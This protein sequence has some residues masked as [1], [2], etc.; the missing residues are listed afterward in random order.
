MARAEITVHVKDIPE[1]RGYI[2]QLE[3]AVVA[4]AA[5]WFDEIPP[6]P[7]Q[8]YASECLHL[9]ASEI[10]KTTPRLKGA[11]KGADQ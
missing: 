8:D 9:A 4:S 5:L 3:D 2:A 10:V 11:Y 7:Q 6:G 1:V